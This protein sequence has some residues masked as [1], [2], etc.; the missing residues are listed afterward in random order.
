MIGKVS[1]KLSHAR[2]SQQAI[3]HFLKTTNSDKDMHTELPRRVSKLS[4]ATVW[5][6][7]LKW[8]RRDSHL[9]PRLE[10]GHR[11]LSTP[12]TFV[13]H[14]G[15][16]ATTCPDP[17]SVTLARPTDSRKLLGPQQGREREKGG[18]T[19]AGGGSG[20]TKGAR[21][22]PKSN[23]SPSKDPSP[24]CREVAQR[25]ASQDTLKVPA[26]LLR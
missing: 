16:K 18:K 22:W 8:E 2:N 15:A 7:T 23:N 11:S 17:R 21:R 13:C 19:G 1:A 12:R 10:G 20:G 6:A 24:A 25:K 5:G 26:K 9:L 14:Q 3:L 4:A